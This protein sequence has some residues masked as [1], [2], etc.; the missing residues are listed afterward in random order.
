MWVYMQS[1]LFAAGHL[2]KE[3]RKRRVHN[4]SQRMR[5]VSCSRALDGS[6]SLSAR[7]ESRGTGLSSCLP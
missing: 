6:V 4:L 3:N 5:V 1:S 2:L 7:T